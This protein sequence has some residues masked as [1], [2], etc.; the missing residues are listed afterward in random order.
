MAKSRTN[1]RFRK[2]S[3]KSLRKFSKTRK[4]KGGMKIPMDVFLTLLLSCTYLVDASFYKFFKAAAVTHAAIKVNK[5]IRDRVQRESAPAP[6]VAASTGNGG[7]IIAT[8]EQLQQLPTPPSQPTFA[9][10]LP[11]ETLVAVKCDESEFDNA[12]KQL[13]IDDNKMVATSED[14]QNQQNQLNQTLSSLKKLE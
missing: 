6:P 4:Y 5:V 9:P 14:E 2:K 3:Q 11:S 12:V 10:K 7:I 8:V 1:R 13:N